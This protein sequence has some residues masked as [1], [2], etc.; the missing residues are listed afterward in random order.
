[1]LSGVV[2]DVGER[3]RP[4]VGP[5]DSLLAEDSADGIICHDKNIFSGYI[6]VSL[7]AE[8]MNW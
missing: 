3:V 4:V 2:P 8:M 5:D 7:S 1:M 6:V